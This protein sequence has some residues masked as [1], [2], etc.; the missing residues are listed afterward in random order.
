MVSLT[1]RS[2]HP[3]MNLVPQCQ[4]SRPQQRRAWRLHSDR[5]ALG[6]ARFHSLRI[7]SHLLSCPWPS[8]SQTRQTLCVLFLFCCPWTLKAEC[9]HRL[10]TRLLPSTLLTGWRVRGWISHYAFSVIAGC[11]AG[12]WPHTGQLLWCAAGHSGCGDT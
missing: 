5:K 1:D 2:Q 11:P 8:Y 7:V 9:S 3:M 4:T 12:L 10:A 6:S